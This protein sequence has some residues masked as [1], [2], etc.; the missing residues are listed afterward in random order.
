MKEF[1]LTS[2]L[3]RQKQKST[4]TAYYIHY[5]CLTFSTEI[6]SRIEKNLE[7]LLCLHKNLSKKIES[8]N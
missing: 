2:I 8:L 3:H 7:E 1:R 4:T 5:S 6:I